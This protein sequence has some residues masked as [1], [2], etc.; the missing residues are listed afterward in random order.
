MKA[1]EEDSSIKG[2]VSGLKRYQFI[3]TL[4]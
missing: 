3:S 4:G 1:S 2:I